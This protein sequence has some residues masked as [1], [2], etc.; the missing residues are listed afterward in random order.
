MTLCSSSERLF[1]ENAGLRREI[2]ELE[3]ELV[4][5]RMDNVYVDKELAGRYKY[6]FLKN[7]KH[8]HKDAAAYWGGG[9]QY[10]LP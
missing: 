2:F 10:P 4:G 9:G 7:L 1:A 6:K 5:A 8:L 3:S